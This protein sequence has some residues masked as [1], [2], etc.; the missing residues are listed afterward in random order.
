ML[1]TVG[2]AATVADDTLAVTAATAALA[3]AAASVICPALQSQMSAERP[4]D[5]GHNVHVVGLRF[6]SVCNGTY[7]WH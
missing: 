3:L 4:A 1:S 6:Q 5:F 2:A 7:V